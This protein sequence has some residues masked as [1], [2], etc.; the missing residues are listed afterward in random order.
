[1][2][3]ATSNDH[4]NILASR[5]GKEWVFLG[6]LLGISLGRGFV[7]PTSGLWPLE[8]PFLLDSAG[9]YSIGIIFSVG[10]VEEG[11][12]KFRYGRNGRR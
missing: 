10:G 9:K 12:P 5:V 1:M 7:D 11:T 8:Y 4:R 3:K 2:I 6:L